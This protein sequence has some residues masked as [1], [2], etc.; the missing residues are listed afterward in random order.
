MRLYKLLP[1]KFFL[2]IPRLAIDKNKKKN[3]VSCRMGLNY[4][5]ETVAFQRKKLVKF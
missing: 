5:K 4:S 1:L 3:D 2:K